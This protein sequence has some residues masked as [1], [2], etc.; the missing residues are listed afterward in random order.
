MPVLAH[1]GVAEPSSSVHGGEGDFLDV[2]GLS[3][4]R[5]ISR[6][7]RGPARSLRDLKELCIGVQKARVQVVAPCHKCYQQ[8]G[9]LCLTADVAIECPH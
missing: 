3:R 6:S 9:T 5:G 4:S 2:E 8:K 1:S 7:E